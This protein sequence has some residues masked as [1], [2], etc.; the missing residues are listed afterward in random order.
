VIAAPVTL[1]TEQE[2]GLERLEV[3]DDLRALGQRTTVA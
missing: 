1:E 2:L 3:L